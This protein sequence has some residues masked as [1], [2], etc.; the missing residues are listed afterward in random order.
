M[1]LH[2]KPYIDPVT[3]NIEDKFTYT[4]SIKYKIFPDNRVHLEKKGSHLCEMEEQST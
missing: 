2:N 1:H 4:F 3:L